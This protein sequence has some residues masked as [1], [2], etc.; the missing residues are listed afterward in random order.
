MRRI[1]GPLF[2]AT[3]F[4]LA[5]LPLTMPRAQTPGVGEIPAVTEQ[6]AP[7]FD[8]LD[9]DRDGFVTRDE[10][11]RSAEVSARFAE[12]DK[13]ADKKVSAVEFKDGF[14]AAL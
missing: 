6:V 3:L 4:I 5:V 12:L 7:I 1:L 13:D 10:A 2:F 14:P 11:R 8:Q 9:V